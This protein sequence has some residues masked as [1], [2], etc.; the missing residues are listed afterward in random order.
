MRAHKKAGFTIF[1]THQE[2]AGIEAQQ[3][4]PVNP[5]ILLRS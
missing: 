1:L 2:W 4:V 5:L 3:K